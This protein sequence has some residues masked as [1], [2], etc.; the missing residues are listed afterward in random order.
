MKQKLIDF[1]KNIRRS[2]L[3]SIFAEKRQSNLNFQENKQRNLSNHQAR[4][5]I[6]SNNQTEPLDI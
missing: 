4:R 5:N 2:Q 1:R 6:F 3:E